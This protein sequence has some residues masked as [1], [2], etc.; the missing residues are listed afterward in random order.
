[1]FWVDKREQAQ[2]SWIGN[3]LDSCGFRCSSFEASKHGKLLPIYFLLSALHT[4]LWVK[5]TVFVISSR[6]E[7][8]H[9]V[10]EKNQSCLHWNGLQTANMSV[11]NKKGNVFNKLK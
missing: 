11:I 4:V 5:R 3:V 1:M 6:A 2:F 10:T 7:V 9:Q 8:L